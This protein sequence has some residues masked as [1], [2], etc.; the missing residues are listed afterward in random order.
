LPPFF[1]DDFFLVAIVVDLHVELVRAQYI[2]K[3][4][5]ASKGCVQFSGARATCITQRAT[6]KSLAHLPESDSMNCHCD[7]VTGVIDKR[8]PR[9]KTTISLSLPLACERSSSSEIT[10]SNFRTSCT[11]T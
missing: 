8:L 2:H 9:F 5:I 1:F 10:R 3:L 11:S 7:F 4:K 6:M